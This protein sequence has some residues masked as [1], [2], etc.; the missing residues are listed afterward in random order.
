LKGI[1]VDIWQFFK[2]GKQRREG[3]FFPKGNWSEFWFV[4]KKISVFDSDWFGI[5]CFL[6]GLGARS[7]EREKEQKGS[8]HKANIQYVWGYEL[9]TLISR[10][11]GNC[12]FWI[13][14]FHFYPKSPS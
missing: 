1:G 8:F 13:P 10:W 5:R 3:L 6:S 12:H 4:V 11:V 9:L 2:L 14:V 7:D